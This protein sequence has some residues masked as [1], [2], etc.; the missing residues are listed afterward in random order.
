MLLF[1]YRPT[2]FLLGIGSQWSPAASVLRVACIPGYGTR[3]P[4][5]EAKGARVF[6]ALRPAGPWPRGSGGASR[7]GGGREE[8]ALSC[9]PSPDPRTC[10]AGCAPAPH[11]RP[12]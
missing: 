11:R 5:L 2:G 1:T 6:L 8:L 3:A 4:G 10:A 9:V 7:S 12:A